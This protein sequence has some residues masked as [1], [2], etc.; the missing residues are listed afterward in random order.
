MALEDFTTYTEVEPDNR[1]QKT[2]NHIDHVACRDEDSYLYDDKGIGYFGSTFV[3]TVNVYLAEAGTASDMAWVWVLQNIVDDIKDIVD[4][5]GDYL[6]LRFRNNVGTLVLGLK[7]CNSG[8]QT[9]DNATIALATWYYLKIVKNVTSLVCGI[10]STAELRDAGDGTDGDVDNLSLTIVDKSYRYM[11]ACNTNNTGHA[12]CATTDIEN[13]SLYGTIIPTVVTN[14]ATLVRSTSATLNGEITHVGV[15]NC[16]ERGFE[17]GHHSGAETWAAK[18]ALPATRADG[19]GAV[20]NGKFYWIGGYSPTGATVKVEVYEYDPVGNSWDT[21]TSI[22]DSTPHT[23]AAVAAAYNGKIY[24]WGGIDS[25][26]NRTY[27][28]LRIYDVVGD[29]WST[30]TDFPV[31][32]GIDSAS[33]IYYDGKIYIIGGYRD[34]AY[35]K[36]TTVYDP[37]GDSYDLTKADMTSAKAWFAI[38]EVNG[39][40]YC[41]GGG[42]GSGSAEA[43]NYEYDVAG[44]SWSTK[45]ALPAVRWGLARESAVIGG[46][47]YVSHGLV[48]ITFYKTAYAYDPS[49]D[50]WRTL[51]DAS[52]ARDGASCGVMDDKLYVIGG[53]NAAVDDNEEFTPYPYRWTE[54]GSFGVGAFTHIATGLTGTIVYFRAKAHNSIGWGYGGEQPFSLMRITSGSL[55]QILKALDVV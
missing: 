13:L 50:A 17:W 7:E 53:R 51:P 45:T 23:Y 26:G 34:G 43:T 18:T 3:H 14:A 47:I 15:Q 5:G 24:V 16:D 54:T 29:S 21:K 48:N 41:I 12:L 8:V 33:A 2:A 52:V 49:T 42:Q 30:G 27:K 46:C 35:S 20:V 6:A 9:T 1:I 32:T 25:L 39:K 19:C 31:T 40:I 28:D 10:Y 11:F 44:D 38:G 4:A 55:S 36:K 22:P 37:V